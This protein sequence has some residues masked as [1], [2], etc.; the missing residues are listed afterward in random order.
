M[1]KLDA[2]AS[3]VFLTAMCWQGY[4]DYPDWKVAWAIAASIA[5]LEAVDKFSDLF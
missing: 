3:W 1:K 5:G 2:L 4:Y